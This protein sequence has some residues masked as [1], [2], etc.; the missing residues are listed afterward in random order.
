MEPLDER[1]RQMSGPEPS[2]DSVMHD[3]LLNC[4]EELRQRHARGGLLDYASL[5]SKFTWL[6]RLTF[7]THGLSRTASGEI[8]PLGR[9]VVALRFLPDY[10]RRADRFEMLA[11]MEPGNAFHPNLM[12]Q[13]ICV[14]V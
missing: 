7:R 12:G 1:I 14:E 10:L 9:H 8:E 2:F 6:Y 3:F 5:G 11:L 4:A 13:H